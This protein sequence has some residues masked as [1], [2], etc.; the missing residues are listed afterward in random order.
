[1]KDITSLFNIQF[2]QFVFSLAEFGPLGI[3]VELSSMSFCK[4]DR[5]RFIGP[6]KMASIVTVLAC[7]LRSWRNRTSRVFGAK[8]S[9]KKA[10]SAADTQSVCIFLRFSRYSN[11]TL[12][13]PLGLFVEMLSLIKDDMDRVADGET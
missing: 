10:M 5:C 1:M 13:I 4:L 3:F 12:E 9:F 7:D 8:V 6:L 11:G 2:L